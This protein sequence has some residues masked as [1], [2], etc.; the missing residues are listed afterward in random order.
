MT[1]TPCGNRRPAAFLLVA[2]ICAMAHANEGEDSRKPDTLPPAAET[3]ME[4]PWL[5]T[6]TVSADPKLGTTIGAVAG[7]IRAFDEKS[8]PSLMTSFVT[9]SDTDS[10]VGGLF[11]DMYFDADKHRVL[12]GYINGK[13]RNEYDD[14]LGSGESAKTEDNMESFFLRYQHQVK[15]EWYIG[16]ELIMS[17]NRIGAQGI[18]ELNLEKIGQKGF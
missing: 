13:I 11:G 9:Y 18:I 2:S 16:G 1:A 10:Y 7:Y 6:P 5:L 3:E 14:F 17:D 15:G 4:S 12:T 8:S